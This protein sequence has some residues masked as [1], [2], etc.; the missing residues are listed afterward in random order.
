MNTGTDP[1]SETVITSTNDTESSLK[2][3]TRS[4]TASSL[5]S[6]QE[7]K[8]AFASKDFN[9]PQLSL[10][11]KR[12][13]STT[14][15]MEK[16]IN[17]RISSSIKQL[18]H[19]EGKE[20]TTDFSKSSFSVGEP[21]GYHLAERSSTI[22]PSSGYESSSTDNTLQSNEFSYAEGGNA[23]DSFNTKR[24]LRKKNNSSSMQ[25]TVTM[26]RIANKKSVDD[27]ILE[28]TIKD[29][30]KAIN[31]SDLQFDS[32]R[33]IDENILNRNTNLKDV[34]IL[35]SSKSEDYHHWLKR[36]KS[37]TDIIK[38][39]AKDIK[40][41]N[42]NVLG[43]YIVEDIESLD[44]WKDKPLFYVKWLNYPRSDNTWETLENLSECILLEGFVE[45]QTNHYKYYIED[46]LNDVRNEIDIKNIT[47]EQFNCDLRLMVNA[48][49]SSNSI[50]T[51]SHK[52]NQTV[53]NFTKLICQL[54]NYDAISFKIDLILMA[55]MK[56]F[57]SR[58]AA[59]RAIIRQ[60]IMHGVLMQRF[61][62][63]R[64]KQLQLLK[65]W[66]KKMNLIEQ[67]A[68]IRIENLVDF[69]VLDENFQ[70][71]GENI[72]GKGVKI[73]DEPLIGCQCVTSLSGQCIS[74]RKLCCPH[75]AGAFFPY[76][77]NGFLCIYPGE[78]IYECNSSC[79]CS[80][81]CGNRVIQKGRN[82]CLCLFK[83]SNGRGWGVKTDKA[84]QKGLFV[85]E[86]VGE[87]I[88]T[89]EA[90]ERG[91]HYDSVGR[92][93][94]FDLDYNNKSE[95][96]YS[97]DAAMFGNIG[98]FFNHSCD[99]NLAVF[100]F[101]INNLDIN[102]PRLAFFSLRFIKAGEE[103]TFDYIRNDIST[104]DYQNLST[105]EKVSC[106]CG[107]KNCRKVLF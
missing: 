9:S 101:W 38:E 25:P 76:N 96:L 71:I 65:E 16:S 57:K 26:K 97:I 19:H 30:K 46:I 47:I 6:D 106:R 69:D 93:Y 18:Q 70:Y 2:L 68:P 58:K 8:S 105:A 15:L 3:R 99:P 7:I 44:L 12:T 56:V 89:E 87:V 74:V 35:T 102:I 24:R 32:N 20:K 42:K 41:N 73:V 86:Y 51:N 22:T 40:Y 88:T 54:N 49:S 53:N 5:T 64:Q 36:S 63:K 80:E 50:I 92:T 21:V 107:A 104:G 79:K 78:A 52:D 14:K 45:N 59:K 100:P 103:L 83:T 10:E 67:Q 43:E 31:S 95:S 60:R 66:E 81:N 28:N 29:D 94:L 27:N 4:A 75:L 82:N 77:R 48:E 90:N 98:H 39:T 13:R 72:A 37:C 91:K 33:A 17:G 55:Q 61:Q 85:A 62:E 23:T 84:L 11:T 34:N 1:G